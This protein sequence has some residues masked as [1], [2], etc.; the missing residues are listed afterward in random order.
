MCRVL[1]LLLVLF[2]TACTKPN[3]KACC[4]TAEDCA[5][6]ELPAIK[7]CASDQFCDHHTCVAA[8][9]SSDNEC[10]AE[11]PLCAGACV[12]CDATHPCGADKPVCDLATYTCGSCAADDDCAGIADASHC[13]SMSGACVECTS[14]DQCST[15]T[16]VCDGGRC[17]ACATDDDCPSETCAFDGTCVPEANVL[18]GSTT[19]NDQG[20]C[21]KAAP[22]VTFLRLINLA[23][24]AHEHI[25]YRSPQEM[26]ARQQ[27]DTGNTAAPMLFFHFH[28]ASFKAVIATN[29]TALPIFDSSVPTAFIDAQFSGDTYPLIAQNGASLTLKHVTVHD[30]RHLTVAGDFTAWDLTMFN[31]TD[32]TAAIVL[33]GSGNVS[34]DRALIHDAQSVLSVSSGA[35]VHLSNMMVWGIA[36]RPFNLATNPGDLEFSTIAR[37]GDNTPTGPC[38]LACGA[39]LHVTGSIIWQ[40][41]CGGSAQDAAGDCTFASSIV[42]NAATLPGTTNNDP[43]FVNA[44]AHDYHI[45]A[46]SPAVDAVDTGPPTDFEGDKRPGGVKFDI[47]ADEIP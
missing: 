16:P 15:A 4:L 42:S 37:A 23:D 24:N 31:N 8:T 22:C 12:D 36:N 5:A 32:P 20:T 14:S 45:K 9:C 34:I 33:T 27:I 3:P 25:S 41:Q 21:T 46:T 26:A 10:P 39:T 44:A 30:S 2:G 18:Y 35:H 1:L 43:M 11:H 38:A 19:G 7:E 6:A 13:D 17:R 28:G 47:G 29:G 40:P